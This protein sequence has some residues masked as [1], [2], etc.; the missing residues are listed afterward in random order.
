MECVIVCNHVKNDS[1][2]IFT[3]EEFKLE[4]EKFMDEY[5]KQVII[6]YIKR[7][8]LEYN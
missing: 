2:F 3:E 8:I 5:N 6:D 1:Q 4:Q 7:G